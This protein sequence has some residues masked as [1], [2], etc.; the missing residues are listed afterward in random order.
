M[1][2]QKTHRNTRLV[3]CTVVI[4]GSGTYGYIVTADSAVAQAVAQGYIAIFL[5][6]FVVVEVWKRNDD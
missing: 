4:L 3:L 6:I 2:K 1:P 5:T